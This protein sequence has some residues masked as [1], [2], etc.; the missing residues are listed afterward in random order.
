MYAFITKKSTMSIKGGK[1]SYTWGRFE[2]NNMIFQKILKAINSELF[3]F[4]FS[5][6]HQKHMKVPWRGVELEL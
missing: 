6:P 4:V 5:G 3:F 1:Q 2:V